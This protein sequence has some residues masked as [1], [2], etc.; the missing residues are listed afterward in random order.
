VRTGFP[1]VTVSPRGILGVGLLGAGSVGREVARALL[2]SAARRS[3]D[4]GPGLRLK[5][6]A[7]R[8][9]RRPRPEIP[10]DILT[11]A[12]AHLV[13]DPGVDV[14]VELM[15]G[16]EPAR[17]LISAALAAGKAVV[18][19]NKH[20]LARHGPELEAIARRAGSA[21]R[22]EASVGGGIPVLTPLA[23]ELA[24]F[25]VTRV[26]GIV[27]G[28]S[29]FIL[30][31]MAADGRDYPDALADA[32][33]AGYAEADPTADVE[34]LDAANKLVI[35]SRLA[36]GV[37]ADPGD[38]VRAP[39]TTAGA[40][41]PGISGVS[42]EELDGANAS[43][44]A[45]KLIADARRLDDG[46][47]AL[48]VQPTAVPLAD[49]IARIGGVTN[50]IEV[51]AAQ[52]GGVAF[53]GPGAGGPATS[54]AVIADLLAI[55]RGEGSTWAGL[56]PAD[57]ATALPGPVE[58]APDRG[59]FAFVPGPRSVAVD[60][61]RATTVRTASGT[62]V[63][64]RCGNLAEMRGL[65]RATAKARNLTIYPADERSA[66]PSEVPQG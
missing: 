2:E 39:R 58:E 36:F 22:F 34:G 1:T 17:T 37:W 55:A 16:D 6:V 10:P 12:P 33:A 23:A 21:L 64:L 19:A 43:G 50:R 9:L 63:H 66:R 48:S 56:P 32:Q 60:D 35:L 61:P 41:R 62:A 24:P 52:V 25:G 3:G 8:D 30:T 4:D 14:I 47:V 5:S 27:N 42:R 15:G 54:T 20:V 45:I 40:G 11:D 49:P 38:I 7:V 65:L 46:S 26:R 59:W 51:R 13:A 29:N 57:R 31:E 28:T 44:L 18:T 53:S